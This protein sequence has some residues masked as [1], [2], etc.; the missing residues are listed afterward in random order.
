MI[1]KESAD[2]VSFEEDEHARALKRKSLSE[3]RRQTVERI[4]LV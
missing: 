3:A 1:E 2:A 4:S